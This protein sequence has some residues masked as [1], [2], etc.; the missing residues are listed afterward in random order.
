VAI[1]AIEVDW[2][3]CDLL[4]CFTA[5]QN[6]VNRFCERVLLELFVTGVLDRELLS[7]L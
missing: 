7:R 5:G 3:E 2:F 6:L 4:V 1:V